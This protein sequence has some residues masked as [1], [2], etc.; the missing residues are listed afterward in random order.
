MQIIQYHCLLN[1][2]SK[3]GT[4]VGEAL[5]LPFLLLLFGVGDIVEFSLIQWVSV[6]NVVGITRFSLLFPF[7]VILLDRLYD[8]F[9]LSSPSKSPWSILDLLN[10]LWW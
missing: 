2:G 10:P 1:V 8:R 7:V 6:I 5:S 3:C 4:E 9:K